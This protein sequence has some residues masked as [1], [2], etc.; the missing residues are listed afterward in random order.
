MWWGGLIPPAL[1]KV[2]HFAIVG[3]G[4]KHL[5][6]AKIIIYTIVYWSLTEY[7]GQDKKIRFFCWKSSRPNHI[8]PT[9]PQKT[10]NIAT[11]QLNSTQ[12]WVSLIFLCKTKTTNHKPSVTL[13]QLL[14]NQT[15]PNSVCNLISTQL[16]DLFQKKIRVF[17]LLFRLAIDQGSLDQP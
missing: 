6:R 15:R 11:A 3:G 12:S 9:F 8:A 10:P 1:I 16:E 7:R 17:F 2:S 13:S 5:L 4:S 14:H